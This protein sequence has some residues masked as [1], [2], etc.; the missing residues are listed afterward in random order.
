MTKGSVVAYPSLLV[1]LTLNPSLFVI[2]SPSLSVILSKAK[3]PVMLRTSSVKG[4]NLIPLRTGSAKDL[5]I[6]RRP[7]VSGLLRMTLP[8]ALGWHIK[9][10]FSD[11]AE[12][13]G[14]RGCFEM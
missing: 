14:G 1:I 8:N 9:N 11:Q 3:D 4:K 6:L 7:D 12:F 2:L 10:R 13:T 5:E